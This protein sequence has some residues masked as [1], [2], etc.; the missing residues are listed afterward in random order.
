L[1]RFDKRG[2]SDPRVPLSLRFERKYKKRLT[3]FLNSK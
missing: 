1:K 3:L 2:Q